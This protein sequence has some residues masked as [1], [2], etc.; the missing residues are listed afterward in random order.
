MGVFLMKIEYYDFRQKYP[1]K[2]KETTVFEIVNFF[3][4][5]VK[6]DEWIYDSDNAGHVYY[7]FIVRP[8]NKVI[9]IHHD[10][11]WTFNGENNLTLENEFSFEI[12]N[13]NVIKEE[14]PEKNRDWLKV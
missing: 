8:L 2:W 14:Y 10:W 1:G 12:I 6:N 11:Y 13:L 5:M 9:R 3:L 7:D 4:N